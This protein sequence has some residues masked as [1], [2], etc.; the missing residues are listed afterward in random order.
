METVESLSLARSP[1]ENKGK[2][3]EMLETEKLMQ[4]PHLVSCK[5]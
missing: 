3:K 4:K 2:K 1:G 5:L